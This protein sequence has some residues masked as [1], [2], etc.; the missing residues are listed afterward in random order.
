MEGKKRESLRKREAPAGASPEKG[1]KRGRKADVVG[2]DGGGA[3]GAEE[4]EPRG[5]TQGGAV[6]RRTRS[7]QAAQA[8]SAPSSAEKKGRDK[9]EGG[10]TRKSH[11]SASQNR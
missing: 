1:Q 7:S 8:P 3:G 6:A 2:E 10:A 11:T 5:S 4:V 9:K